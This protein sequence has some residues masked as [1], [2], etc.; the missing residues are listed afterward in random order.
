MT[1]LTKSLLQFTYDIDAFFKANNI[2]ACPVIRLKD[3]EAGIR[4]LS[5]CQ[6]EL[7]F[8]VK[9]NADLGYV[10]LHNVRFVWPMK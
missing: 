3:K 5:L 9:L 6:K 8:T 1:Q 7:G 2:D 10:D 4:F